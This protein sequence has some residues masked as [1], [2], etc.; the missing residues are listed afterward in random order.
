MKK[1]LAILG[2]LPLYLC[3][4]FAANPKYLKDI[5]KDYFTIGAAYNDYS[6]ETTLS[7]HF[8]SLTAENEM[9]WVSL[10]PSLDT[11]TFEKADEYVK[12]AKE[13]NMGVRGHTLVWHNEKA[14]SRDILKITD[15]AQLLDEEMK[16]IDTVI[17][18]F[19]DDV[20]CWDVV[21][22]VIDDGDDPIDENKSNV[23]RK[24]HWYNVTGKDFIFEAYK[25]ADAILKELGIRD[26]VKLFYNDYDNTKAI[27][28]AKTL[29]M[30]QD[31]IDNNIPIDGIGL[32]CHYHLGSFDPVALEQTILDYSSLGLDIQ[33]TEFD[34][35]I[36]DRS[37]AEII[38]FNTYSEVT[39][40]ALDLHAAIYD[41]AFEIFRKYKDKISN[42]T[43]WGISDNN[44]YM[45]DNED[46]G[47]R[48]NFPYV[49]DVNE[50]YKPAYYM[51]TKFAEVK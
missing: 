6:F 15:K 34:C 23:Y 32:Q 31:L 4:C 38:P 16:H 14:I 13:H 37:L 48:R 41:R 40:E 20:Y 24:S 2:C 9:K 29:I 33:I 1:S 11:Y 36:Y 51:I 43:F 27:K 25:K 30:L 10:H 44:T 21:N 45:N 19:K 5:Y 12:Y 49:F 47:Y 22:E 8:N 18:H 50:E 39:Q 28:K 46:Y 3:G 17:R 35:E 7:N 26:K 42:V